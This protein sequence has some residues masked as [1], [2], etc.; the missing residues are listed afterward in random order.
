[1]ASRRRRSSGGRPEF[2][3]EGLSAFRLSLRKM[4]GD[5]PGAVKDANIRAANRL[6]HAAKANTSTAQEA[7]AAESLRAIRA[8][9]FAGVRLGTGTVYAFALGAEFGSKRYGQFLDWRGNQHKGWDGG[10]GYFLHPA[11]RSEGRRI[12]D[13]YW[14][15]IQQ[16]ARRA[17][18]E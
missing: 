10:P 12:L 2:S 15:E 6:V 8:A 9:G 3:I 7:K 18:P 5:V 13:L 16:T 1:M 11:I 4:S 14:K 17:F